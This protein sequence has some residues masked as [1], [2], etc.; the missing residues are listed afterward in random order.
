MA[1]DLTGKRV[2]ITSGP[3]RADI[4]AVRYISN[5]SSGRLGRSIAIEALV[6][7]ARVT[8]VAGPDAAAPVPDDDGRQNTADHGHQ[9]IHRNQAADPFETLRAHNVKAEP[10]DGKN[11]GTQ[12][13]ERNV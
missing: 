2:L 9:G 3:T 5:R 4:D 8:Y 10:A 6:L 1:K 7:G 12:G 11:P 13:Q